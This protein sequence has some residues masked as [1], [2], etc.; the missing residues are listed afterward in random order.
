[1]NELMN[2][3]SISTCETVPKFAEN[4]RTQFVEWKCYQG[5]RTVKTFEFE[6]AR[7]NVKKCCDH[8]EKSKT[9]S[10]TNQGYQ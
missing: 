10:Q 5:I 8:W 9:I 6:N 4:L 3:F 1:M 2:R 7:S